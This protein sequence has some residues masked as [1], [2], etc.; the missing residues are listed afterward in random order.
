MRTL[1][2]ARSP[3]PSFL[4]ASSPAPRSAHALSVGSQGTWRPP[5]LPLGAVEIPPASSVGLRLKLPHIPGFDTDAAQGAG[6]P[7]KGKSGAAA[8]AKKPPAAPA[9]ANGAVTPRELPTPMQG[10]DPTEQLLAKTGA[11][12]VLADQ[13]EQAAAAEEEALAA[14]AAEEAAAEGGGA[15]AEQRAAVRALHSGLLAFW[16]AEAAKLRRRT[17]ALCV[18][19]A[20]ALSSAQCSLEAAYGRLHAAL[21]RRVTAELEVRGSSG[22]AMRQT[23]RSVHATLCTASSPRARHR[24]PTFPR[25]RRSALCC[26]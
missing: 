7:A 6:A 2:S 25:D 17:R 19:G 4:S 24:P 9:P 26:G 15:G 8:P 11:L 22:T 10:E 5:S 14:Q 18:H 16:R 1:R 23:A 13:L 12:L 21:G 20:A 3:L